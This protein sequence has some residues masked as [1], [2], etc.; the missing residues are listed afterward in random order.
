MKTI[1]QIAKTINRNIKRWARGRKKLI[2]A[3]DG[4]AGSGK[5]SIADYLAKLNPSYLVIHLDDFIRHWKVRKKMMDAAEDRSKIFEYEW[6]CYDAIERL[7]KEF[8]RARKKSIRLKVYDFDKNEFTAPRI[9]DLSKDILI[10]EGIFLL[11]PQQKRNRL[12]GKRVFLKVNLKEAEKRS[13][14]QERK[15]WGKDYL[16]ENHPDS[17]F[18]DFKIA[19]KRYL[20]DHEPEQKA[21]LVIDVDFD[22]K[23][24][25]ERL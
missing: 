23:K 14:E 18:R 13:V 25:R 5:T 15:K 8:L 10:I 6:Y 24:R 7:A 19:Y 22:K 3:I 4:Y 9:F 16:P 21:D 11:H 17:Y 1:E 20:D 2:V 12:W